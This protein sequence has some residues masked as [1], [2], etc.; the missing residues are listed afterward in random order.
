M[1][2]EE[3]SFSDYR[4]LNTE[5]LYPLNGVNIIHGKNAQGKTNFLELIWLFTG[6]KSFRGSK[7]L[8]LVRFGQNKADLA[9]K[10]FARGRHQKTNIVVN[11]TLRS[12]RTAILNGVPKKTASL[13][14]G[15]F[16]A[17]VFSP[18]HLSLIKDGPSLRRKFIDAAI[19]QIK[20]SYASVILKYQHVLNQ[21]NYIL[22][23]LEKNKAWLQSLDVWD[24]SLAHFGSKIICERIKYC[25]KLN[26]EAAKI[27]S[28]L[29]KSNENMALFYQTR[30]AKDDNPLDI[31]ILNNNFKD[32][33][34]LKRDSDI[35]LRYTSIGP[36]RDD[37]IINID[38]N[39]AKTY[40]S[41]GQQRSAVL[42]M[43]L[44]EASILKDCIGENPVILLDDVMSELDIS[45]Q[46]YLVNNINNYQVFITCCDLS[47]IKNL[48]SSSN[49]KTFMVEKGFFYNQ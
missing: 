32:C 42:A 41:Q 21:R 27:Y 24:E 1:I 7:D 39:L 31:E 47:S 16:C 30:L 37:I 8:D 35:F 15:S 22:K 49:V 17:V 36:H 25:G 18:S 13:L 26:V 3:L 44:A 2:I 11:R 6:G 28:Q 19:C 45:R 14:I 10:F 4:N 23:N 43:K 40:A 38:D 20:P 9:M 46:S 48:I 12:K 29:S 5:T 33:L 34:K